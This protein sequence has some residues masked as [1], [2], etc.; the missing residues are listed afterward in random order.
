MMMTPMPAENTSLKVLEK[1]IVPTSDLRDL[2]RRLE[3]KENIPLVLNPP[4]PFPQLGD[5]KNFC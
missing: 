3:G 4:P 5:V 1:T 2:A